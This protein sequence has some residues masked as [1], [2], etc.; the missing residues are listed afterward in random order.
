M[1]NTQIEILTA[2]I[3]KAVQDFVKVLSAEGRS[4]DEIREQINTVI[5]D[6][7]NTQN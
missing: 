7:L 3:D 5:D 6:I 4:M 1:T 2:N